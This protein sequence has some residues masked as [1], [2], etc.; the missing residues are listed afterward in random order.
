MK[1]NRVWRT[2]LV[3]DSRRAY[4]EAASAAGV[5]LRKPFSRGAARGLPHLALGTL[6]SLA[7]VMRVSGCAFLGKI[8]LPDG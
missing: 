8:K 1:V 7:A 6:P 3:A 2:A 4:D 5:I